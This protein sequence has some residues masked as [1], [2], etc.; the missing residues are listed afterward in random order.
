MAGM[1][2][3]T[4]IVKLSFKSSMLKSCLCDYSDAYMLVKGIITTAA[5]GADQEV[6]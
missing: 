6:R 1:E 4:P 2:H 5:R 3:I